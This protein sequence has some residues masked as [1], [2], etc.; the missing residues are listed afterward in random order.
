MILFNK[1]YAPVVPTPFTRATKE[2][3]WEFLKTG[4]TPTQIFKDHN[5]PLE[6]LHLVITE[7]ERLEAETF[8]RI[9]GTFV[10]SPAVIVGGVEVTPATYAPVPATRVALAQAMSSPYVILGTFTTDLMVYFPTY[11]EARTWAQFKAAVIAS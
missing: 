10:T 8:Q 3:I 11:D 5:V 1:V 7:I 9:K 6:D 4:K 2:A